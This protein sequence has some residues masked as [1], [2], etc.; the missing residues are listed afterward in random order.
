MYTFCV[1]IRKN[2][3]Y[4]IIEMNIMLISFIIM[5]IQQNLCQEK[6]LKFILDGKTDNRCHL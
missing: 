1:E 3:F 5:V 6:L 4:N 2:D